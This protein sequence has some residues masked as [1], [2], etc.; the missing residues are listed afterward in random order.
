MTIM[1]R[2]KQ[3]T[4]D[5]AITAGTLVKLAHKHDASLH[6]AVDKAAPRL[7]DMPWRIVD[8]RLEIASARN[9]NEVHHCDGTYCT[10]PTTKGVCWHQGGWAILS[11]IAATGVEVEATVPLPE[12]QHFD[13]GHVVMTPGVAELMETHRAA[14]MDCL[15]RH[16]AHDWGN[17]SPDDHGLNEQAVATGARIL[18]VYTVVGVTFWIITDAANDDGVR[19]ATTLLIPSEY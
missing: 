16:Q 1:P 9:R 11:A 19:H 14:V 3:V 2:T 6:R 7:V 18:S 17:I 13:V 15:R 10:C 4:L 12:P 5:L 8:G